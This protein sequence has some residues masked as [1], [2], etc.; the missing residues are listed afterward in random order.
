VVVVVDIKFEELE[1]AIFVHKHLKRGSRL[2]SR[3]CDVLG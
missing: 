2:A 3:L 1:R